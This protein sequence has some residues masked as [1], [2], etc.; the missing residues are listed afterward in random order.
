M[1]SHSLPLFRQITEPG[2]GFPELYRNILFSKFFIWLS[3]VA[4]LNESRQNH[5]C[6]SGQ[7]IECKEV[8]KGKVRQLRMFKK[9]V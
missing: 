7:I 6:H 8:E 4:R 3:F 1:R 5:L 9:L 2:D